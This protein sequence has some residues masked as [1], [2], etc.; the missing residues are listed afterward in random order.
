MERVKCGTAMV[1][2]WGMMESGMGEWNGDSDGRTSE[3]GEMGTAMVENAQESQNL[4]GIRSRPAFC[5]L[6]FQP[7][8][9][10]S[11]LRRCKFSL[12]AAVN[13]ANSC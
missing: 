12:P 10:E 7:L 11:Q 2:E 6:L 13:L 9:R 4:P 1:M 5:F 8:S 3:M